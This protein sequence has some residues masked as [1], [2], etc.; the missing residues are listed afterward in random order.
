ME[1]KKHVYVCPSCNQIARSTGDPL[2]MGVEITCMVCEYGFPL[3]EAVV[4]YKEKKDAVLYDLN[5]VEKIC[6]IIATSEKGIHHICTDNQEFPHVSNFFRW[7]HRHE[8]ARDLYARARE[9]QADLLAD[10]IIVIADDSSRDTKVITK[11]DEVVEVENTEWTNRSKLRV[12]ARKW[13]ASK[14]APK[15]FG[16]KLELSGDKDR[17]LAVQII[18]ME[19]K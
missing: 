6:E 3:S 9:A 8:E 4:T 17:P 11:G 1:P 18:G 13:K 15:K 14:L 10:N 16:D 2:A 5:V 7:L 19:I 12:E